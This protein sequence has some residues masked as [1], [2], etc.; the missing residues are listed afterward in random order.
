MG[1]RSE[2]AVMGSGKGVASGGLDMATLI[3]QSDRIDSGRWYIYP[4][5]E[6]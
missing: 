3:L 4:L 2:E 6:W 5:A 1:Y